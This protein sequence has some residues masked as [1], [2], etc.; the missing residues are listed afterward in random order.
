MR[1]QNIITGDANTYPFW[2][3]VVKSKAVFKK[4]MESIMK[5]KLDVPWPLKYSSSQTNPSRMIL[6][7]KIVGD[8]ERNTVW[9]HL[10]L[11]YLD[12]IKKFYPSKLRGYLNAIAKQVNENKNFLELF[13]PDGK[14]FEVRF[15]ITE[16]GMLWAVKFL[17]LSQ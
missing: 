13:T 1:R 16:E 4:C 5:A 14:P 9:M 12:C 15:H 17:D 2:C 11:C 6:A 8:Y 10:G 3:G 7:E